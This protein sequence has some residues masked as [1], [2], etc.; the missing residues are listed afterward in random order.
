[1]ASAENNNSRKR[2]K[3]ISLRICYW[4]VFL[5]RDVIISFYKIVWWGGYE[6]IKVNR[7]TAFS[8]K[9]YVVFQWQD[10]TDRKSLFK[11]WT[12]RD[13]LHPPV[14]IVPGCI[15]LLYNKWRKKYE[16]ALIVAVAGKTKLFK[17]MLLILIQITLPMIYE[18]KTWTESVEEATCRA[19][20]W[21]EY[22]GRGP[23]PC[24]DQ[25]VPGA[26]TKG[27]IRDEEEDQFV[28]F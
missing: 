14:T 7:T 22:E 1:M 6:N 8:E 19:L 3:E 12:L 5:I 27:I 18:I 15:R 28:P 10:R 24:C 13:P 21:H 16:E 4:C 2:G 20:K 9:V 23:E 17:Y 26:D 11:V 25:E